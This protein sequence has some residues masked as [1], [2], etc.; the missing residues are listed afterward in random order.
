MC[1]YRCNNPCFPVNH[2]KYWSQNEIVDIRNS[3]LMGQSI[4]RIARAHGRTRES[5]RA[6]L[7]G[8]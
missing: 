8:V 1:K 7:V 5:I 3:F 2:G 4:T 6:K